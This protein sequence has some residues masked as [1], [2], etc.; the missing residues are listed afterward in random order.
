MALSTDFN[1]NPYY[2]DYSEDKGF[3][4]ILFRPGYAVQAR[5]VTQLQT[6]LQKQIE[7]YGKHIFDEG[8]I[9]FGC[10]LNYDNGV[11]SVKLE[12]QF[13]GADLT[14]NNFSNTIVT[15]GTSSAKARVVGTAAST[16]TDQP[17]LMVQ[18]LSDTEFQDGETLTV[19]G[20][21][22]Q[23]NTVSS[24]GASG[25]A[26]SVGNGSI[27][28]CSSGVFYVGGYFIFKDAETLILEKY[29]E[30]PSYRIG[31]QT[32]ESIVTSDSDS[33]LL[34][35]AQGAYNYAA[36]GATRYKVILN[37]S[38]KTFSATDEVE[39][40]A[41]AN[42]YQLMKV[43]NGVKIDQ[44]KYPVY[45]DLE[46]TLARR[47]FDES[48]D[49]TVTPF[50]LQLAD[51]RGI[52]G[53][54]SNTD[55]TT[56]SVNLKGIGTDFLNEVKVGDIIR[57]SSN[58][59]QTAAVSAV[60][61]ANTLQTAAALQVQNGNTVIS[62]ENKLSAGLEAGKAY[63]KGYEYESIDTKF[64]TV[65]KGRDTRIETGV[66]LSTAV[67][68][69][70]NVKDANGVFDISTHRIID[71]HIGNVASQNTSGSGTTSDSDFTTQFNKRFQ[72]TKIGTARVRDMD[73]L[74][75][76]SNTGNTTHA[77]SDYV[78]YLYDIRTSNN[79]TGTVPDI[80]RDTT[81]NDKSVPV[82]SSNATSRV[83]EVRKNKL[84]IGVANTGHVS[85]TNY[86]IGD[87][88]TVD[89]NFEKLAQFED[90]Y[91]GATVKVT[92]PDVNFFLGEDNTQT[93]TTN[94]S[95]PSANAIYNIA[96]EHPSHVDSETKGYEKS[97]GRLV[98][99]A[100][101][102]A[103]PT[104]SNLES[105]IT[106]ETYTRRIIGQTT[107]QGAV[108]LTLD[109]DLPKRATS[110]VNELGTFA[111]I[112]AN[113]TQ[114]GT[115]TTHLS[116]TFD[117][118][119]QPKDIRSVSV[120]NTQSGATASRRIAFADVDELS[121]FGGESKDTFSNTV[122]GET[123]LDSLV[124]PI[125]NQPL[126]SISEYQYTF[127]DIS[128]ETASGTGGVATLTPGGNAT[129]NVTGSLSTTQAEENFLVIV[130]NNGSDATLSNGQ[131]LS[132]SNTDGSSRNISI[133]G[134]GRTATIDLNSSATDVQLKII[135]TAKQVVTQSGT[136]T[137]VKT[138]TIVTGNTTVA[139]TGSIAHQIDEGQFRIDTPN[140]SIGAVEEL[141]VSD[142]FNIVKIVDSGDPTVVVSNSMIS[143]SANNITNSYTL[144]SGQLDNYY[145][146]SS[147]KLKP[148]VP[149]PKGRI[150]VIYDYFAHAGQRGAFTVDSY[151][152]AIGSAYDGGTRTFT[153]AD[154]PDFV[155]PL[156]GETINLANALDF[157]PLVGESTSDT[158]P[159]V[160]TDT[161]AINVTQT[162]N[163]DSDT[164]SLISYEYYLP[165]IDKLVLTRDRTFEVIKGVP[166]VN[167]VAPPD[168]EDS[169]TL[170]TLNIPAYTYALSDIETR[171]V[172][173]KR[174]TMRDIGKLEKR[175]ERL[176]YYT[177]LN[178]L[179]KETA[180]RSITSDSAKDTLFNTTG[181]RFKNGILVDQ[182]AGHSVGDVSLSDYNA[183]IH[184]EKRQLRAPFYYD[185][186]RFTFDAT[187]SVNVTKTG[188]LI[189][190][191]YSNTNFINQPLFSGLE[192]PN[193]F[194]ILNWI[195][196]VKLDPPSDT[197]Y[198]STSSVD[199]TVN[200]EGHHD[201]WAL[202]A[203]RAGFG[204]QW[205]DWSVNW[206]GKQINPEPNT[207]VSNSGSLTVGTRSTKT[208][209]QGK[210]KFGIQS[211][212]PVET[213]IKTVNNKKVDQSVIPKVRGQR[214]SFSAKGL[215]PLANV[216]VF[217]GDT[218]MSA[219]TEPAKKL[220][221]SSANGSFLD[222][223][224]IK[225]SANNR[226]IIRVS[227]NT[228]SNVA[229]LHITDI[230]GNTSA[231]VG[232]PVTSQ[233][234]RISNSSVGFVVANV[235]TGLTSGANGTISTITANSRGILTS[236]A[237]K[238]QTNDRGEVAGDIDV[239][240]GI[241]RTGDRLIRL[242]DHANNELSSATT[243]GETFFKAKGLLQNR[244]NLIVST[245]EPIIRRDSVTS[246][247][248]VRDATQ[249]Q[250]G[251]SNFLN[252]MAQSFFVDANQFPSGV[253]LRNLSLYFY[254]KDDNLPVIVQIRPVINGFPSSSQI[255]P[256]SE[257]IKNP[258]EITVNTTFGETTATV[259]DF[260]SPVYLPTGE[261]A[262]TVVTNSSEYR[263][264][265][266]R[267][268][269]DVQGTNR[270]VTPQ[271]YVGAYFES[272]N[273]GKYKPNPNNMLSF[274]LQRCDFTG[275]KIVGSNNQ[276]RLVSH[277]N[278]A[279]GNTANV[280]Y[281][282]F[283]T[284]GSTIN[285][286]N[287][288]MNFQYKSFDTS[289]SAVEFADFSMDQNIILSSGRQM[290]SS[291]NGMFLVNA[292][293]ATVNSHISPVIDLDRMNVIVI[294]NDIDN[295]GLSANDV[296]IVNSGNGYVNVAPS[297]YTATVSSSESGNTAT[298]NVHVE[299]TLSVN[300]AYD[301]ANASPAD[302]GLASANAGYTV[303]GTNPGA[304]VVGEAIRVVGTDINGQDSNPVQVD[305][306]TSSSG[307]FANSGYG[308]IVRQTFVGGDTTKNVSSITLKTNANTKGMFKPGTLIRADNTAQQL[309]VSGVNNGEASETFMAV[310]TV[311]GFVSNV[312][313][314]TTGSGYLTAPTVTITAPGAEAGG[315]TSDGTRDSSANAGTTA[316]VT[317]RGEDSA[318]GGN[319]NAKYISRRV[320]LEDGFD[321]SDIKVIV[322]AYKPVGTDI[323]VYYK[324]KSKDDPEN[325]DNKSY[326]LMNQETISS[327]FSTSEEDIREFTYKT[328]NDVV[329]Y[330][331]GGITYD[332]FKTFAVKIVMTSNN[333]IT[334][335]KL[336]DMRAI[337]LDE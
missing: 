154:I 52:T 69:K 179:E 139:N 77:H 269:E 97:T 266:G 284:T 254:A 133:S 249:R 172:D 63:V 170:Y 122:I 82:L 128:T 2:D 219:N 275:Q 233:N 118:T 230:N 152:T 235:V 135:F 46:N 225:D 120:S 305:S 334:I 223:E 23:A 151:N 39:A 7:R 1:V 10:D 257:V 319:I 36:Q 290:T 174:F 117:I 263:L 271:N 205:N 107:Y 212:D 289:N 313:P 325:F 5:E 300:T 335:P 296:V 181:E 256:F 318:D 279:S 307:T 106:S 218:D 49:Y 196:S 66:G 78:L 177:S 12:T 208:I 148:G 270:K 60:S 65:D 169:M 112:S 93:P 42:F 221:L 68:N 116:S 189:T 13:A 250:G 115:T 195:G 67:G 273:S 33:T 244:E 226:G 41:D 105:S 124:F 22:T 9:V 157:R 186:F 127:K 283:K 242:V 61:S 57:L 280:L 3:Y 210:S 329:Q 276:V 143:A 188:D 153:Y 130:N 19:T 252:P 268:G 245:R 51:H 163:P 310:G 323:N 227:S 87:G 34:D 156:N 333:V 281:Q 166:D 202:G 142:V 164:T 216:Y 200:L 286:S 59:A 64:V 337:A 147:I 14:I 24:T 85:S 31:F 88:T 285:F 211:D 322:S 224:E 297:A 94:G 44:V 80:A 110:V 302:N 228:T 336:R 21:T 168:D 6:I 160:V 301:P 70:L 198:D 184:F 171:Y 165:R 295:G 73:F 45:S 190:L 150:L 40:A 194:N 53:R 274:K 72:Q 18:F 183:S 8:S 238:M 71:L 131:Y 155:S 83:F 239:P 332:D 197:W 173:N 207:A 311:R 108:V 262:I 136:A 75:L 167:P 299:V 38:A 180:S 215:K 111:A 43:D 265:V 132:F 126:K 193:P 201:N 92:V 99:E 134:D 277:A 213:I 248:V 206:S 104:S 240:A 47:T 29:S 141:P 30:T 74:S 191:P 306:G 178:F 81:N 91:V 288:A 25:L 260:D 294:D 292:S 328:A 161:S 246:E 86:M 261:Y 11:K 264:W 84:T 16:A 79:K 209:E 317:I 267:I 222:G 109:E 35:P 303:D 119:F 258:D 314:T 138:K 229:T 90:A 176:E 102:G 4:R 125:P 162:R 199:V 48:G 204:T 192:T 315:F 28:S 137:D 89:S 278:G 129:F 287:T 145:A 247:E 298:M 149:V 259:F 98:L 236:G 312:F 220:V 113:N 309:A 26:N 100:N 54:V 121:K 217:I 291:T 272:S 144:D 20:T 241:F 320:S 231:T 146:H 27:V 140:T 321:A 62:F 253:F 330:S 308:I 282:T 101:D 232:S 251:V 123:E 331:S 76:S 237:S 185:N 214:I 158:P 327:T 50:N 304:F 175:I 96:L 55:V 58:T 326:V 324:V 32:T 56:Q 17:T 114:D 159:N 293:M 316:T 103:S 243:V 95:A 182:F 37:L 187:N 255:I 234:N 203:N 15:G